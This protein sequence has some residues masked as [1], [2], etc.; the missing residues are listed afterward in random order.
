MPLPRFLARFNRRVT[1]KILGV[2]AYVTPPF[3]IV[4]HRGRRSGRE[5]RTPVW[6]FR[7]GDGFVIPLT[8]GAS[9]TDWVQNVL[10]DG[11]ATLV[12]RR[13][14]VEVAHPRV[15]HGDEGRRALPRVLRPGLRL[16]RV[17]DYLVVG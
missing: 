17:D 13:R 15:I 4:V 10:A 3:T 7:T 12:M 1:N 11:R 8:Y 16:L 5:Y 14:R 9:R 2:L 6:A